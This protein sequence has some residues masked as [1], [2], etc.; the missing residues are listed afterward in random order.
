MI[1]L[2]VEDDTFTRKLERMILERANH[3]IIEAESGEAALQCL[4]DNYIDIILVDIIMPGMS[5]IELIA[6]LKNDPMTAR[7]PVIFCSSVS[8]QDQVRE[9]VALGVDGYVLKPIVASV[10][11]KKIREVQHH[12]APVLQD[13]ARTRSKLGLEEA[14]Y[15]KLVLMMIDDARQ[16]LVDFGR[17]VEI[18]E[19]A[20]FLRFAHDLANSAENLGAKALQ[21]SAHDANIAIPK[22]G[23][24]VREKYI[25]KL[26]SE[27]ERL[28][29]SIGEVS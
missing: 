7:I 29:K 23:T 24:K 17:Q 11:T 18:G 4:Q 16:K 5:G 9:A 27:I 6:K 8:E 12:V 28:R 25:F 3:Q 22:V 26:R 13:P 20:D 2:I 19:V 15:H 21:Q 1:I 14:E 10:L